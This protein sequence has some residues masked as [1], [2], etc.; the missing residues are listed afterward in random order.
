MFDFCETKNVCFLCLISVRPSSFCYKNKKWFLFMNSSAHALDNLNLM[1][2]Y[3]P[4]IF[5]K[6][7]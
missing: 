6:K 7:I 2:T 1:R 5:L 4:M 3:L